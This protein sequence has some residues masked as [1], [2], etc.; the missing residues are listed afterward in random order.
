M[1]LRGGLT[2]E[3]RLCSRRRGAVSILDLDLPLRPRFA[4]HLRP[5]WRLATLQSHS[6]LELSDRQL[7]VAGVSSRR[8]SGCLLPPCSVIALVEHS[9]C[10]EAATLD[11]CR[12]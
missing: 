5:T 6:I 12:Q 9:I 8:M 2:V 10:G 3:G 1:V 7:L 11:G 4:A